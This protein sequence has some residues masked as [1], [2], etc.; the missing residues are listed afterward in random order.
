MRAFGN[1]IIVEPIAAGEET[2]PG[3]LI[4]APSEMQLHAKGVVVSCGAWACCANGD[5]V[6]DNLSVGETVAY[7][8]AAGTKLRI[9]GKSYLILDAEQILA[10]L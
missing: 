8:E 4:L 1:K 6:W 5:G 9:A 10:V 2:T 3:G 7:H